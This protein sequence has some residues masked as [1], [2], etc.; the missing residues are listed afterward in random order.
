MP[1]GGRYQGKVWATHPRL[2]L[3]YIEIESA[4]NFS[5]LALGDSDAIRV[6][7][8]VI[9]IGFP[10]G[11]ELGQAPSVTRG[12]ISAKRDDL[13]FLQTDASLNP[14]NSG[15]P[16][17]DEYGCVVGVNT[18][19]VGE[20]NDGRVVTGINFAIPVNDLREA[21]RGIP[22]I[23]VCQ[24]GAPPVPTA[25]AANPT[26]APFPTAECVKNQNLYP[27]NPPQ[28]TPHHRRP[29]RTQAP[30]QKD[31]DRETEPTGPMPQLHQ[32]SNSRNNPL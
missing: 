18:A 4:T 32:T 2:D 22:G 26:P 24:V 23:P 13:G 25:I 28:T 3:A 16:L 15:G 31:T 1:G 6:G 19:G 9:A 7:A 12:I 8:G 27:E 14:G 30:V 10:L 20:T 21:L 17:L 29:Q 11:S 5:S